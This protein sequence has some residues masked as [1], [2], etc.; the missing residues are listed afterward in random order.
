MTICV[1][2]LGVA[3]A[4]GAMHNHNRTAAD[5]AASEQGARRFY[6]RED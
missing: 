4:Y 3:M 1:V 5:R 2:A 6:E